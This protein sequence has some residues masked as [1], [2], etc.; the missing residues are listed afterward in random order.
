MIGPDI[1]LFLS[2][3]FSVRVSTIYRS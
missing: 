3:S 2:N 1:T